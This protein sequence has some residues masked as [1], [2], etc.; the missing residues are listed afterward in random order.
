MILIMQRRK[1]KNKL[2]G[3]RFSYSTRS[4][5][6]RGFELSR[7]RSMKEYLRSVVYIVQ[8]AMSGYLDI[9]KLAD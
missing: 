7:I 6:L 2:F 1:L 3:K 5:I 9:A 4:E 8:E